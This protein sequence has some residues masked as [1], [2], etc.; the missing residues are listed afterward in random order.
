MTTAYPGNETN[1]MI[2]RKELV[3]SGRLRQA[4]DLR[5]L[6][7]AIPAKGSI[8]ERMLDAVLASGGLTVQDVDRTE[9]PYQD[10]NIALANNILDAGV[11]TEPFATIGINGG[12]AVRWKHWSEALPNDAVA[13][14]LFSQSFADD[15][16][17]AANRFAK[18]W[19]RGARDFYEARTKG[20]NRE[21]VIAILQQYTAL[22]ERALYD[23]MP[24]AAI[25]PNGRVNGEALAAQQDWFA[26]QGYLPRPVDLTPVLDY[27]FA[28]NAVAQLGPYPE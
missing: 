28:D 8:T 3:D 9:I 22:K 11:S 5:G 14:V 26:A 27:R 2:A 10:M 19:V 15:R 16:T 12:Y 23:T 20:V 4:S 25:N 1:G 17:D 7:V 6:R 21:E 18:A 24:W 13:I